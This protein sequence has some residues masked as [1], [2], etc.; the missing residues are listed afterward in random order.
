[1]KIL[2][3][4]RFTNQPGMALVTV[5]CVM[6]LMTVLLVSLFSMSSSELKSARQEVRGG[7]A[8]QLSEVAVNVV[9]SQ[10]RKAARSSGA[11]GGGIWTTQPGLARRHS[12]DGTT[13]EAYKLYS[14]ARMIEHGAG[15][16]EAALIGDNPASDWPDRPHHYTDLNRPVLRADLDGSPRLVFPILDPRA[17]NGDPSAAVAGFSYQSQTLSGKPVPGVITSGGDAQR[18]PMPVEWLYMLKDGSLGALDAEG[19]YSGAGTPSEANPITARIAFWTDDESSKI[20]VNTAS[21]PTPWAVPT[22]YYEMDADYGRF[23]PAHGEFPRYPGHPAT[24]ALSPVLFPGRQI[25]PET[26][27]ALYRLV[28]KIG[29]GGSRAGTVDYEDNKLAAVDLA[30]YRSERLYASLDE[31]LLGQD[32]RPN[33][34]PGGEAL[35][36]ETL[37][38][39]AFFLT[40]QSR[41]P[42]SN[43]FGLPKVAAWPVSYR[44]PRHT[45]AFDELL[46]FCATLRTP[47]GSRPYLFQRGWADSTWHDIEEPANNELLRYLLSQLMQPVPGFGAQPNQSF[48]S[49]Y[50]DDLPQLLV[51]IFDYIRSCNTHD[52]TLVK[53]RKI[54]PQGQSTVQN[55]MLGYAPNSKRVVDFPTFTDPRFFAVDPDHYDAGASGVREALGF[56]G[57][58]QVTPSRWKLNNKT[59]QGIARFPTITEAGLHFICCADNTDLP[60]NNTNANPFPERDTTLGR[61]GGGSARKTNQASNTDRWYSNFPPSPKPN[62]KLGDPANKSLFPKTDGYPYGTDKNHPGYQRENWNHQLAPNKP[63]PPGFRRVQARLLFEFFVPAAGYTIMEPD[64]TLRV[65]G[66]RGFTLNGKPLF[67]RDSELFYTGRRATHNGC[68]MFGGYGIG[69]KGLLREREAPT[70]GSMPADRLWGHDHWEIRPL[71]PGAKSGDETCVL[72]YDLLSDFIDIDVGRDGQKPMQISSATLRVEIISGHHGR[73]ASAT[74]TPPMEAQKL[75]IPF[76][77]NSVKAPTLVR[78]N[79]R[80]IFNLENK[81]VTAYVV[82]EAPAWWTFYSRGCMGF[83]G[84]DSIISRSKTDPVA[85]AQFRG[86]FHQQSS[87]SRHGSEPRFGAFFFGFDSAEAGAPRLFRPVGLASATQGDVNTAEEVQGCDVVQ[88]VTIRHGDYRLTAALP[89]VGPEHW[90]AHRHYGKRR[91]AHNFTCFSSN[92]LPGYD[93]G[94]TADQSKRLVPNTAAYAYHNAR[95]PD[96]PFFQEAYENAQRFGDFDNGVGPSRDGPYINKPDD[97]NVNKVAVDGAAPY[98]SEAG[99]HT[100]LDEVFFTPNRMMPSPVMLG[101]LPARVQAREPWRTLLFRPQQ[102]HPGG[103]ARLGGSDPPDH[104]LL[105]FFWMPVVEPYAISGPFSTAGKINLNYQI[106]PFTHIRRATG[107]HAALAGEVIHAVPF[108]DIAHYKVFPPG[109]NQAVLWGQT[110]KKRWHYAVDAE[111]T[112]AQCEERFAAGRAF[113]SASEICDLHLVPKDAPNVGSH[114]DMPAF[115]RR[116]LPTGDNIRERPYAGLYPRLT[117]RSNVFRVHYVTQTIQKARSSD[118]ERMTEADQATSEF[119]G[120]TLIE[121]HLD[122]A[123]PGLPDFAT[124]AAGKTLDDFHEFRVLENKRFGL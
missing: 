33:W 50:R 72:N 121:R 2:P 53:E 41:A 122:P 12:G 91:L 120:S 62:P 28:P 45:T 87:P 107:L 115:W 27:E 108:E 32:R 47:A 49:K 46:R 105:E 74:E 99:Q 123:H 101:S 19:R 5:V 69:V 86:R 54:I 4:A 21:E 106:L 48:A 65:T 112:L 111:K 71:S 30:R 63:L 14:S 40:A 56:P 78:N 113:T 70:R 8:Q 58:G 85:P 66:L 10:L 1:M 9:I 35:S 117:A 95:M 93:Y 52:G 39:A 67:P 97:G 90:V 22:F 17:H 55:H 81:Q 96:L 51:L 89:E 114:L 13:L 118:P 26:K 16:V 43:P 29:P 34:L 42:E 109:S 83:T 100:T 79:L 20:N 36:P 82:R 76:P 44:G 124:G 38:R 31:F 116:H 60:A 73:A 61:P 24:T 25:T 15:K 68:Q 104:L 110:Q 7:Q 88:T 103:P 3:S 98:L 11:G 64:L 84:V 94:G 59:Y 77:S 6:A 75:V 80:P 37:Q 57:H 23:Q 18:L 92:Q 102:D 119:R